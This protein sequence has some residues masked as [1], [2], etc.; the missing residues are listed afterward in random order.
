MHGALLFIICKA[1]LLNK[2]NYLNEAF[3]LY[4][5]LF[6]CRILTLEHQP[7]RICGQSLLSG[8]HQ[9]FWLEKEQHMPGRIR[10]LETMKFPHSRESCPAK[11]KARELVSLQG[12]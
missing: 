7:V 8:V 5:V 12:A 3:K 11:H 2:Y 1:I 10:I 4:L 6:V 9:D